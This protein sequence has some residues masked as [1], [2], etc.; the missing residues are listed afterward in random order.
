VELGCDHHGS[1]S[2]SQTIRSNPVFLDAMTCEAKKEELHWEQMQ[3][4]VDSLFSKL[5]V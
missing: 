2:Q 1:E 3:E 4:R 5:E